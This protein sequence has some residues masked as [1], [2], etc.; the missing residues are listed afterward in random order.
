MKK[1]PAGSLL[2][3]CMAL[4]LS[5][6]GCSCDMKDCQNNNKEETIDMN[7][8]DEENGC[9]CSCSESNEL[10]DKGVVTPSGLMYV[11]LEEAPEG[12]ASP[13][14]G[15]PVTV[16]YT[17]WLDDNGVLG[18]QFDSSVERGEPFSFVIGKGQ[19][20]QGWDEGVMTMKVGEKRRL[21]IP[22]HLA[23]GSRGIPPVIPGD[24][25][26]V[27]DVELISVP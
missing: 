11:T 12:A 24:A 23:Y 27:F 4:L 18:E 17:G 2:S 9:G 22:A 7:I 8:N 13:V 25:T 3:L 15:Q 21:V 20:I 5:G 10:D 6:C 1:I 26:L 19:V 16:H 14:K